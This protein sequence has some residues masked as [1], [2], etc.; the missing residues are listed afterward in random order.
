MQA[1]GGGSSGDGGAASARRAE[2]LEAREA[3]AAS[4][5]A[6]LNRLFDLV[7]H[8]IAEAGGG[9]DHQ[10]AKTGLVAKAVRLYLVL[11]PRPQPV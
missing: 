6:M 2:V 11:T 4:R 7:V 8:F 3:R 1:H 10:P 9:G 5:L